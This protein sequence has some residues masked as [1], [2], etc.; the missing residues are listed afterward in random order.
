MSEIQTG[1]PIEVEAGKTYILE[2]DAN[3]SLEQARVILDIF[4]KGTGS[5]AV[6]L[7][8]GIKIAVDSE[9]DI[10]EQIAQEIEATHNPDAFFD[11]VCRDSEYNETICTHLQDAAIARGNK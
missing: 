3:I 5:K 8:N 7:T 4:Q 1:K 10:R 9:E 6:I 11:G 2:T